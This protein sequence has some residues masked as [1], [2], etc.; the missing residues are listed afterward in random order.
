MGARS[1]G[2]ITCKY[3]RVKCDEVHPSCQ[4]CQRAGM[5]CAGFEP[6]L[7]FIDEMGRIDHTLK[8]KQRQ[9]QELLILKR[10]SQL[11]YHSSKPQQQA[12]SPPLLKSLVPKAS[13]ESRIISF[14]LAKLYQG[15]EQ[16][17]TSPL[18]SDDG[19][20][21][22]IVQGPP[23]WVSEMLDLRHNALIAL[24]TM[25][26]GYANG[27]TDVM[28]DSLLLYGK[29]LSDLRFEISA[30]GTPGFT[31]EAAATALCMFEL[32]A[33]RSGTSWLQH[34]W[35]LAR[36]MEVRGPWK[37]QGVS[38]R[39][40]FL[41]QR[42]ILIWSSIVSHQRTFLGEKI[43]KDAPWQEDVTSKQPFDFLLDVLCDI[44]NHL[45]DLKALSKSPDSSKIHQLHGDIDSS[46][47][48]L[49]D[50][51]RGWS[52]ANP[53]S[54]KEVV[55]DPSSSITTDADG[56]LFVTHLVYDRLWTAYTVTTYNAARI[57]LLQASKSVTQ[58]SPQFAR[59][60]AQSDSLK[61]DSGTPL[62]GINSN[63]KDLALEI[64][65]SMQYCS[66]QSGRFLG[67]FA[68]VFILD[69]AYSA[70]ERGSREAIWL[71]GK[72]AHVY[73]LDNNTCA[74]VNM[75]IVMIP[76]C[77]ISLRI[78]ERLRDGAGF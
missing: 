29:A 27:L 10:T 32:S 9:Q 39:S 33:C 11:L 6:S 43:W 21:S 69:V 49:D 18:G 42:V 52:T 74:E 24:A 20:G 40:L 72:G 65:R 62:L 14:L 67:T 76:S 57:L 30:S 16:F 46:I 1:K 60:P 15:R 22:G 70:L 56:A 25:F 3:R 31:T 51:W 37:H 8:T 19:H 59:H 53:H 34:S 71:W 26:F 50:W 64:I 58:L 55:T 63:S 7:K 61:D 35:G 17:H 41:E 13:N 38:E 36:L 73:K 68:A 12:F 28:N 75:D 66:D 23:S 44:A 45:A 77:Q 5:K 48:D 54:C 47:R 4:R 2:C 78:G